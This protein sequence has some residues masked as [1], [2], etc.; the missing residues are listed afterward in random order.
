MPNKIC[1]VAFPSRINYGTVNKVLFG[2]VWGLLIKWKP[3]IRNEQTLI[4]DHAGIFLWSDRAVDYTT[5]QAS[6]TPTPKGHYSFLCGV[7]YVL[8][9]GIPWRDL[10]R[11]FGAWH[12][13]YTR[14]KRWSEN[15]LFWFILTCLQQKKRVKMDFTWVDSTTI[16]LHRHGSG[17]LKKELLK[18]QDV[19]A[20]V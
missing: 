9:T 6:W 1:V 16:G 5:L 12:T 3:R 18:Q 4:P 19:D 7:L 11:C 2:V 17:Y 20:K 8:R 15:G 10:P 14:F 13:V